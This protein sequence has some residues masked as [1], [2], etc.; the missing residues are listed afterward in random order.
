MYTSHHPPLSLPEPSSIYSFLFPK[1]GDRFDPDSVA[2]IDATG[3]KPLTRRELK[4]ATLEL[5]WGVRNTLEARRGDV[6]MI[7]RFVVV[8]LGR[9]S[10]ADTDP[11]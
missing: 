7:F 11:G 9:L 5:A 3:A 6:A 8:I 10:I 4:E 1:D 2:F